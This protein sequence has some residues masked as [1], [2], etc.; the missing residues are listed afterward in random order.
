MK[1]IGLDIGSSSIGW[2]VR[3]FDQII[4]HGVIVFKGG[5]IKNS[6]GGYSS[7]TKERREKRSPRNLI[8]ARKY[9]TWE[10]LK[11]LI[12]NNMVPLSYEELNQWKKYRNG[13]KR[14]FPESKTFKSWL[15][16]NFSY[17][18]VIIIKIHI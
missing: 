15:S 10:L 13:Q 12:E 5:M 16:C 17:Q 8:R 11:L 4:K 1:V 18:G 3:E 9:R 6:T 14:I 7:P 2:F